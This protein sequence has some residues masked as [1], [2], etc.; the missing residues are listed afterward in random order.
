MRWTRFLVFLFAITVI[1]ASN[2]RDMVSVSSLNTGPDILLI[3]LVYFAANCNRSNTILVSFLIGFAA[4]V[5]SVA[6]LI[7]PYTISY[8]LLGGL[9][10]LFRRQVI[11]KR[12]LYQSIAIFSIGIAGGILA[13]LLI[14]AKSGAMGANTISVVL[15]T[16]FYSAVV[17]PLI[18]KFSS[19]R[20]R[21]ALWKR[22]VYF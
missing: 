17:G 3:I 15:L 9:L 5:S 14:F 21:L 19:S 4:D 18:W 20:A 16:S 12:M 10:S 11:R 2:L 8:G 22:R 6:M 13:E 7:G 1:H